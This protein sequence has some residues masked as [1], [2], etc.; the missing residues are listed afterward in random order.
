V[1]T[2]F[3]VVGVVVVLILLVSS[4]TV[5]GGLCLKGVGCISTSGSGATVDNNKTVTIS[6]P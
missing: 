2:L 3:I 4:G 6:T 1:K 5:G